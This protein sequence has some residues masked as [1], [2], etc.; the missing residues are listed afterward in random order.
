MMQV[1]AGSNKNVFTTV[2]RENYMLDGTV[3]EEL[4]EAVGLDKVIAEK[5]RDIAEKDRN[6]AEMSRNIAEKDSIIAKLLEE[7]AAL[8]SAKN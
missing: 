7:N 6:I 4:M 2:W 1:L 3:L 5:D 8:K